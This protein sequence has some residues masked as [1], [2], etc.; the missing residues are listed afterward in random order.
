MGSSSFCLAR[1]SKNAWILRE[2]FLNFIIC[3]KWIFCQF[4]S[5][6]IVH[7]IMSSPGNKKGQRRGLCGHI[8]ASFDLHKH[9]ARC[10]DKKVGD[11]ACVENRPCTICDGFMDIQKEMLSIPTYKLRKEKKSGFLVSPEDVTVVAAVEDKEPVFHT[12]PPSSASTS[13]MQIQD[14]GSSAYVTSTQLKE[15]SDQ[16]SE[17]FA[18]FKALL[19]R[20]NVFSTPKATVPIIPS[21]SVVSETP[22]IAHSARLTGP[23]DFPAEGEADTVVTKSKDKKKSRKSR[24]EDKDI[25]PRSYSPSTEKAREPKEHSHTP[26]QTNPPAP[27]QATPGPWSVK[28]AKPKHTPVHTQASAYPPTQDLSTG[29]EVSQPGST[30]QDVPQA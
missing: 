8:M 20:G 26:A 24:K 9:C 15:I 22:F 23:V 4:C 17:Q 11:D 1:E 3:Y 12:S 10:R 13:I 14:T 19:S 28:Q 6:L 25:K 2:T 7:Y 21:Q 29:Q 27:A 5:Q 16:W 30:S 18:R